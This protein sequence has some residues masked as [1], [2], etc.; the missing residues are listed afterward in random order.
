MKPMLLLGLATAALAGIAPL[1]PARSKA[2][3]KISTLV[4]VSGAS[5][6]SALFLA[7]ATFDSFLMA[8][9]LSD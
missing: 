5:A 1:L 8:I 3:R 6:T 7:N 9:R 2:R 4:P